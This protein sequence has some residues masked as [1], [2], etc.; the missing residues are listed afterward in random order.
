MSDK[1]TNNE[2]IH[3]EFFHS[4][5]PTQ[6]FRDLFSVNCLLRKKERERRRKTTRK[7]FDM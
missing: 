3:V 2:W 1:R 7:S 4:S 6:S 5:L